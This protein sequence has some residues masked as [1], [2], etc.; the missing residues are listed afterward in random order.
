MSQQLDQYNV[1]WDTPSKDA[2]GSMPLGNGD[3]AV[4]VWVEETGD[5]VLL[6]GKSDAWDENS[7]NLKLGRV[8][9]MF[10]PKPVGRV[11]QTLDL[12]TATIHIEMGEARVRVWVD[13]NRAVIH[14]QVS[15]AEVSRAALE[16]WRTEPRV[17]KTQTGDL[18]RDLSG[19]DPHPT[20]VSADVVRNDGERVVWWHHNDKRAI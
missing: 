3:I 6:I 12:K 1:V 11:R 4:N 18:F 9:V 7:I 5:L 20:V 16:N 10:A 17:I 15:G 8:R 19:N 13:A 2:S 14:V